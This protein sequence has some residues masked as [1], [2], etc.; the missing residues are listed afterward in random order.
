[1]RDQIMSM[2]NKYMEKK[3]FEPFNDIAFYR[4]IENELARKVKLT[5][6]DERDAIRAAWL[7]YENQKMHYDAWYVFLID[8]GFG[9][10]ATAE[11]KIEHGSIVLYPGQV[12]VLFLY[13]F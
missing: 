8:H 5:A 9:R 13:M 2:V 1:M 7:T 10:P 6:T 12:R 3:G 11:E 4:R